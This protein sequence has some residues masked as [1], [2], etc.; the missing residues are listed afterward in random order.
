MSSREAVDRLRWLIPWYVA[1]TL[2]AEEQ[3]E[4]EALLAEHPECREDFDT[5]QAARDAIERDG[6]PV[7]GAHPSPEELVA[8][9]R[10]ELTGAP[11]LELREHLALCVTCATESRWIDRSVAPVE[12]S[13][14]ELP[15][16]HKAASRPSAGS[17]AGWLVAAGLAGALLL[18]V[19]TRGD[20]TRSFRPRLVPQS[21]MT[22][23]AALIEVPRGEPRYLSFE[24]TAATD[25]FPLSFELRRGERLVIEERIA[26]RDQL[27]DGRLHFLVCDASRCPA[28][29]YTATVRGTQAAAPPRTY[30]FQIVVR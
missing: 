25:E 13:P 5:F 26:G 7:L 18:L 28:G 19:L 23:G 11:L 10:G 12:T 21:Q 2:S 8:A 30:P 20:E 6:G 15:T 14:V 4:V 27:A 16:A 1:G 17:I 29:D 3:A 24:I 22:G 9:V